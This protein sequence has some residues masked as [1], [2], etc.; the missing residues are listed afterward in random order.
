MA[1]LLFSFVFLTDLGITTESPFEFFVYASMLAAFIL[2]VFLY[3]SILGMNLDP[4]EDFLKKFIHA[5]QK[6]V[7]DYTNPLQGP[8]TIITHEFSRVNPLLMQQIIDP[9][10]DQVYPTA[11]AHHTEKTMQYKNKLGV[12]YIRNSKGKMAKRHFEPEIL[13]EKPILFE[14]AV[15]MHEGLILTSTEQKKL[16]NSLPN[17]LK[18]FKLTHNGDVVAV[19]AMVDEQTLSDDP[20]GVYKALVTVKK[21]LSG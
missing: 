2:I 3:L 13:G 8:T 6:K 11:T 18:G 14:F 9:A 19:R 1:G 10:K 21:S 5:N 17:Q 16:A 4:A 12:D 7:L 15:P 20:K